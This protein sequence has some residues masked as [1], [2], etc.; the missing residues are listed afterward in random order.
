MQMKAPT[1]LA[2]ITSELFF[3]M[4]LS[5][6]AGKVPGLANGYLKKVKSQEVYIL[7]FNRYRFWLGQHCGKLLHVVPILGFDWSMIYCE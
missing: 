2:S 4:I 1:T 5:L 3:K 7:I 6:A